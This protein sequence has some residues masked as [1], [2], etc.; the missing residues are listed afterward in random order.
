MI[1]AVVISDNNLKFLV[2]FQILLPTLDSVLLPW[3][4]LTRLM[5][6][7]DSIIYTMSCKVDFETA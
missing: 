2:T 7:I 3:V 4:V 6:D 1:L 5:K